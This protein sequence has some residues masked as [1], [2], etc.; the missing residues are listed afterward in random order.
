MSQIIGPQGRL[1]R[2]RREA[3]AKLTSVSVGVLTEGNLLGGRRRQSAL[4]HWTGGKGCLQLRF[5]A[6]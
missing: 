3:E 6:G 2:E 5:P 4:R 1:F